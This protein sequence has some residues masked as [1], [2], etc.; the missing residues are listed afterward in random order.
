[1]TLFDWVMLTVLLV[2][3]AVMVLALVSFVVRL[4]K[5]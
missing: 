1:M 4:F 5:R 2:F 3:L